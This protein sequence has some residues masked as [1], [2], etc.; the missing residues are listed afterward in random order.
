MNYT[1]EE[2]KEI[3]MPSNGRL[4]TQLRRDRVPFRV[5]QNVIYHD[6]KHRANTRPYNMD[7]AFLYDY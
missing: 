6:K 3:S 4:H 7:L 1:L 2:A 5:A